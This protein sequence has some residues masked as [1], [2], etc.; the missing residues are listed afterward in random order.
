MALMA[1][2]TSSGGVIAKMIDAQAVLVGL[3]V[4]AQA[5]VPPAPAVAL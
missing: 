3:L 1:A 2:A 4:M 5:Y